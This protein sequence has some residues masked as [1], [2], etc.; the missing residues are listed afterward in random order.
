M[1]AIGDAIFGTYDEVLENIEILF[2]T[3][4]NSIG[5]NAIGALDCFPRRRRPVTER[6]RGDHVATRLGSDLV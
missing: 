2:T 5:R 3:F 1:T 4:L 6:K